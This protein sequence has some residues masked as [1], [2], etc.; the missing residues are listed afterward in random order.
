MVR[1]IRLFEKEMEM[2]VKTLPKISHVLGEQLSLFFTTT[3]SF[4]ERLR[5]GENGRRVLR[6]IFD[7]GES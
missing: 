6:K 4:N 2:Y 3:K 1:E 5:E 7:A